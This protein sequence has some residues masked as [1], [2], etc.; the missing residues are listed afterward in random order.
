MIS[1]DD[2]EAELRALGEALDVPSPPPAD[3]ARAVRARLARLGPSQDTERPEQAEPSDRP[4]A[5]TGPSGGRGPVR[6]LG[7]GRPRWRW[8]TA[9]V[10]A[11]LVVLLGFTPQGKA[12]VA[13]VLRFAGVEIH[14]GEPGPLPSGV[15]RPLPGEKRVSLGEA[16]KMAKFPVVVP[17]ELGDP[18]DVRVIE[19]GRVVS[20]LWPGVRLD[21][22][23]G[24]LSVVWRK[25]L[26]EPWPR[27]VTIGSSPG[28]WI[29][30]PHGLTYIPSGGGA[31]ETLERR[32]GPTL[33]W[34]RP[35]VAYRLEG[36]SDPARAQEIAESIR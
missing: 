24:V 19:S 33:I 30:G 14:V 36:P 7:P 9:G 6:R 27:E 13:H 31:T 4:S 3:V 25:D 20:L 16:R 23:D 26:G 1:P 11:F 12:A 22:Y 5:R 18:D 15:P 29:A 28:W 10:A 21:A 8:V 2:F 35:E 17:A 34:Q 32:A